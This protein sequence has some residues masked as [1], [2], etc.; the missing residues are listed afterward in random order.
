VK[1]AVVNPESSPVPVE[2]RE[3]ADPLP[4]AEYVVVRLERAA[5]NRMD[6]MALA[7]AT[8]EPP[9]AILGSDGAGTVAAVGPQVQSAF[10]VGDEVIISPSINWGPDERAPGPDYE[11]VGSPRG[12]HAELVAVPAVNLYPKPA[13]LTWEAASALPLAGVTAWRALMTRG[14]L[15]TGET[16]VIGAASSGVGALGIQMAAATGA[17]VVA[18]TSGPDK[19]EALLE[20]GAT[21]VVDRTSSSFLNDLRRDTGGTAD[22]ALD[23]TGALWQTFADILRPGGR[24]VVVGLM[25]APVAELDVRSVYWK[26]LDVLGSSMGSADDFAALVDHVDEH[27]WAPKVDSVFPLERVADAY[28]RLDAPQRVGKVVLDVSTASQPSV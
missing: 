21:S 14:R 12:T 24:L 23:P 6:A 7:D 1:A 20:L 22:L 10:A 4:E 17:H 16:V 28:E 27:H 11:F 15:R 2:V 5:L 13:H 9:G 26:Q 25:V 19:A 18:L 3:V 8:K